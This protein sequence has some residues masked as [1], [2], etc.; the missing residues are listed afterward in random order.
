MLAEENIGAKPECLQGC[1]Y[2][3]NPQ[4]TTELSMYNIVAKPDIII[5]IPDF[6]KGYI[7]LIIKITVS[8]HF[9]FAVMSK[10]LF[11]SSE[12]SK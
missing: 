10:L 5:I 3:V 9:P 7:Y 1:T 4:D 8:H 12:M 6:F 2:T 11:S